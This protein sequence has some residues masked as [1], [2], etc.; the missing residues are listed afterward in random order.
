M[1]TSSVHVRPG[2]AG[3]TSSHRHRL[4]RRRPPGRAG[5]AVRARPPAA[6]GRPA[7]GCAWPCAT[8]RC[9]VPASRAAPGRRRCGRPP[10]RTASRRPG[11]STSAGPRRARARPRRSAARRAA[12]ASTPA[13]GPTPGSVVAHRQPVG[14]DPVG[15]PQHPP[16][17]GRHDQPAVRAPPRGGGQVAQA[18]ARRR[19]PRCRPR[20]PAP[21]ARRPA[22]G[23]PRRPRR[24]TRRRPAPPGRPDGRWPRPARSAPAPRASVS[25]GQDS[26]SSDS[27][28]RRRPGRVLPSEGGSSTS[29]S[30]A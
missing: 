8:R 30:R 15:R 12:V 6:A 19:A 14:G 21:P 20:R 29:T 27:G 11:T 24:A 18:R 28:P 9:A 4:R 5:C 22:C 10:A 7:P 1:T 16:Q 25:S 13:S 3:G 17:R 23:S 26:A 2:R